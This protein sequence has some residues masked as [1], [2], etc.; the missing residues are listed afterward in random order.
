[1]KLRDIIPQETSFYL[2]LIDK[3]FV[4][5][6][7]NLGHELEF[8]EKL[9]ENWGEKLF[10]EFNFS[11]I[12]FATYR[13]LNNESKGYLVKQEVTTYDDDGNEKDITIGGVELL[14]KLIS[15]NAEKEDVIKALIENVGVNSPTVEDDDKKKEN[16]QK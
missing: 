4:M 13:L 6:P 2:R 14:K 10:T 5:A 15:G 9:G 3:T 12:I 1:L 8:T 16:Q 7:L 11:D